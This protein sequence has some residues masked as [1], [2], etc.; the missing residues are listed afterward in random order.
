MIVR[1]RCR[2]SG[3]VRQWRANQTPWCNQNRES[4]HLSGAPPP[5]HNGT[6]ANSSHIDS[7]TMAADHI[8]LVFGRPPSQSRS[9]SQCRGADFSPSGLF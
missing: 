8:L 2:S 1:A 9:L 7:A 4:P 5:V 3:S 6:V